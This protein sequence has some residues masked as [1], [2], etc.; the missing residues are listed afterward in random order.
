MPSW[1]NSVGQNVLGCGLLMHIP[2]YTAP[3]QEEKLSLTVR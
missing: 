2:V 3:F 1:A